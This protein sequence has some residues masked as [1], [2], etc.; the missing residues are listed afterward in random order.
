[1]CKIISFILLVFL[2]LAGNAAGKNYLLSLEAQAIG[3]YDSIEHKTI[4][5]SM[6]R[7]DAM[8]K[9]SV[10]FD[11]LHRLSNSL[12]DWGVLAVQ[13]RLAYNDE[14]HS[15]GLD[16]YQVQLY[17]AYLKYK[18]WG[19]DLWIGHNRIAFGMASYLDS[20]AL[21]LQPLSMYGYG[22]DRDWGIGASK[23]VDWGTMALALSS[24]TGMPLSFNGNY[25]ITSR[26]SY[27]VLARDNYTI[28]FSL[29]YGRPIET[30]GYKKI[31]LDPKK[32]FL[33]GFDA[34][35]FWNNIEMR[36][37]AGA[38]ENRDEDS[39][40]V[41]GRIGVHF[42]DEERVKIEAQPVYWKRGSERSYEL[43]AGATWKLN[44]DTTLRGMYAYDGL[45]NGTRIVF[46]VYWY[47]N[48]L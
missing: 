47:Y 37:E 1:M 14:H 9:S 43:A 35:Y 18:T 3:G 16:A 5:Y 38:G 45:M 2:I 31:T 7:Y 22:Y 17:N 20:H 6:N 12:G 36:V 26:G 24:G 32:T 15:S 23:D 33:V 28:G 39:Y 19:A 41:L 21:L 40:S 46:Q 25:F 11:Y 27:G 10:G 29:A 44:A 4:L 34:A 48:I 8:Q 42:F 13:T 30:M